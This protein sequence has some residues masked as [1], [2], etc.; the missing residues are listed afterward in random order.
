MIG[1]SLCATI[2]SASST[3]SSQKHDSEAED[4]GEVVTRAEEACGG[5]ERKSSWT[6]GERE[7]GRS[8]MFKGV[9]M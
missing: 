8:V 1:G 9:D 6:G 7:A 4:V 2:P 5:E 3:V